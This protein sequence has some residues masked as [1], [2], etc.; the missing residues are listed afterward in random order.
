VTETQAT[1]GQAGGEAAAARPSDTAPVSADSPAPVAAQPPAAPTETEIKPESGAAAATG[2]SSPPP[3]GS[4]GNAATSGTGTGG[5]GAGAAVHATGGTLTTAPLPP[6]HASQRWL[7][8]Q[9]K[10]VAPPR[11]IHISQLARSA[12]VHRRLLMKSKFM[13]EKKTGKLVIAERLLG[14]MRFG[15][16][17]TSHEAKAPWREKLAHWL[18]DHRTQLVVLFLLVLDL[19]MVFGEVRYLRLGVL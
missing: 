10:V 12:V 6:I 19:M 15:A 7:L 1:P 4:A 16:Q 18:E 9:K 13:H 5:T 8:A 3:A 17:E 14:F 2:A 11:T